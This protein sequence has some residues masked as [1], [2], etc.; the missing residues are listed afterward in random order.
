VEYTV[1]VKAAERGRLPPVVLIHGPDPQLLDDALALATRGMFPDASLAL[2]GR[3]VL[4]ARDASADAIVG[5]ASTLPLMT[6]LRLV[7]VRYA[8]AIPA[9]GSE[10]LA[11]YIASPNPTTC[12]L[13]LAD[14]SLEGRDGRSHWLVRAVPRTAAV[15]LAVRRGH[16][17]GQ[18]LGQR[19]AAEGLEVTEEAVR[20]LVEWVGDDTAALLGEV[21]KAAL[22]G[23][24]ANRSVGMKE[25]TAVVGEHRVADV[26]DLTG[27]IGRRDVGLAL[28]ILDRLLLT[29]EPMRLLALLT[30]DTRTAWIAH[31]L[32]RRG[33]SP[34]QIARTVR[35][36][37]RVVHGWL[38]HETSSAGFAKRLTRCWEVE[39][40]LKSSGE[41]RAEMAALVTYLGSKGA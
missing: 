26:F 2:F 5:L 14:E 27:A 25:V 40:R 23:G 18:W 39:T 7:V 3:E 38:A 32:G 13:L 34:E 36:P 29:E 9:K 19:A 30:T 22:A 4:D 8:Q 10:R 1:F 20:L 16:D 35:R 41:A 6:G 28:R 15:S 21:R 12:L 24:S 31:E 11:A 33:Q 17:L 37:P